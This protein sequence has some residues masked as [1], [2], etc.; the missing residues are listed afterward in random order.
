M[1]IWIQGKELVWCINSIAPV[2]CNLYYLNTTFWWLVLNFIMFIIIFHPKLFSCFTGLLWP[3][4]N[5]SYP[6]WLN[7]NWWP[8]ASIF[9]TL[10]LE[11]RWLDLNRV[12]IFLCIV[13][14]SRHLSITIDWRTKV[15][16]I[17]FSGGFCCFSICTGSCFWKQFFFFFGICYE[18]RP[19]FSTI[20]KIL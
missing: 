11:L 1:E 14:R 9:Q 2:A 17:Y 15:L 8:Y 16:Y 20:P 5:N 10:Q 19:F 18:N 12:R 3:L 4:P 6:V 13:F 7:L